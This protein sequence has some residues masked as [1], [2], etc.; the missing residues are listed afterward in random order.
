M[1][2]YFSSFIIFGVNKLKMHHYFTEKTNTQIDYGFANCL[3]KN[4]EKNLLNRFLINKIIETKNVKDAIKLID[5]SKLLQNN[6]ININRIEKTLDQEIVYIFDII[7]RISEVSSFRFLFFVFSSKY[8]FHNIKVMIKNKYISQDYNEQL[9]NI[10]EIENK[11][12]AR[13]IKDDK[14]DLLPFSYETLIKKVLEE[15]M[16]NDK[17]P[18]IIDFVLDKERFKMIEQKITEIEVRESKEIYLRDFIRINKE[19]TNIIN[20]IRIKV[21]EDDQKVF[22]FALIDQSS[23]M[24]NRLMN[25]FETPLKGWSDNF[26][27]TDYY[28][29]INE[30]LKYYEKKHSFVYLDKLVDNYIIRYVQIGKLTVFGIEPL[31]GFITAKEMDIKNIRLMLNSKLAGVP[32]EEIRESVRDCYV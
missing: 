23:P 17:N 27:D 16:V 30:G 13:V 14:Y 18:A 28:H 15:F 26:T 9:F 8:I 19:F 20:A 22:R 31:V 1:I 4:L 2:F 10:A 25:L 12:I 21:R 11:E 6:I 29:T 32:L 5:D 7:K 24:S 3:I